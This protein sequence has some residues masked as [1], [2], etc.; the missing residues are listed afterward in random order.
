[1][2]ISEWLDLKELRPFKPSSMLQRAF[3]NDSWKFEPIDITSP[4]DFIWVVNF[5]LAWGNFSNANFGIL[6]TI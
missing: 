5:G 6:V 2:E 4:T 3:W 1:M